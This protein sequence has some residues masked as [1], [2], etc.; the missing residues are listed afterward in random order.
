VS[1]TNIR[2]RL[3]RLTSHVPSATTPRVPT[4]ET[5]IREVAALVD[6][7]RAAGCT[8][9]TAE[10]EARLIERALEEAAIELGQAV[11]P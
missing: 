2:A 4:S 3:D 7:M 11:S 9:R 5:A 8:F 10:S 6:G 1:L